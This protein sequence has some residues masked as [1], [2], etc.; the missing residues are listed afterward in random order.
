[1]QAGLIKRRVSVRTDDPALVVEFVR[2][3]FAPAQRRQI[4]ALLLEEEA[5]DADE[6]GVS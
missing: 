1:M 5:E 2:T 4:A 3:H 6:E